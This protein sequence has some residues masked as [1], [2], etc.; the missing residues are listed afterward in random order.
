MSVKTFLS[1]KGGHLCLSCVGASE[2]LEGVE[3]PFIPLNSLLGVYKFLQI[4]AVTGNICGPYT[5]ET[6]LNFAT[7]NPNL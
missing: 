4:G 7:S 5:L 1:T 6:L 3:L 2:V